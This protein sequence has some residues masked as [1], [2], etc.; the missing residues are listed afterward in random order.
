MKKNIGF[1]DRII[2]TIIAA[3]LVSL[4]SL[5]LVPDSFGIIFLLISVVLLIT[6]L[7]G[8]CPFYAL[9]RSGTLREHDAHN[10]PS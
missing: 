2:R 1:T 8:F 5:R 9:F 4:F 10:S 7:T 6:A 3:I